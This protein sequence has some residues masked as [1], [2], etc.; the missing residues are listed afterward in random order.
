[1]FHHK[2]LEKLLFDDFSDE[3]IDNIVVIS[4]YVG[5]QPIGKLGELEG[6]KSLI[7]YGMYGK[8]GI[9]APLH[10]GIVKADEKMPNV[11]I[12]YSKRPIHSKIY[13]GRSNKE[14]KFVKIG[15]ANIS[16]SGLKNDGKEVL[17]DVDPVLFEKINSYFTWV[18]KK[19]IPCKKAESKDIYRFKREYGNAPRQTRASKQVSAPKQT[20]DHDGC[21]L[22]FMDGKGNIPQESGINWC[23]SSKGKVSPN[24]AY[25]PIR[26]GDIRENPGLFL[27]KKKNNK[28]VELLWDDGISMDGLLEASVIVDGVKYP[29]QLCSSP[30]KADLGEYLRRRLNVS[31]EK[32]VDIDDFKKY[33]RHNIGVTLIGDGQYYLDFSVKK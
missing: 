33:G 16:S 13:I 25:I 19:C 18:K 32:V 5:L 11:S 29:K 24:D 12:M 28:I 2:E 27:P 6:K 17:V 9:L 31:S 4:G 1:M 23:F 26:V 8:E 20:R 30:R 22:D 14:I 3:E 10:E 15:S 21:L 7:I